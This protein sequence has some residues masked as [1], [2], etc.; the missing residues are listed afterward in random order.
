MAN[1]L[2]K[3][4]RSK[5][6]DW[7]EERF[8]ESRQV[9]LNLKRI[10][11]FPTASALALL[12]TIILLFVMGVNFQNSLA[13]GLS[14]WLL[15]LIVISIFFTYRN[16][17]GI[18][19]KAVNANPCFAGEKAVFE[20]ALSCPKEQHK[21]AVYIGWKDQDVALVDLNEQHSAS[22][23]LS[24]TTEKR[25]R[26]KP[27]RLNI[28]TRYPVGL[29]LGWSYAQLNME[30]IVYPVPLLQES[31]QNGQSMDD[32]AEQ[33]LEIQRG[34]TDFSGIRDYQAGDSPKHIHWGSYAKTGKVFSKTFVDYASH[35]LWLDWEALEMQ[36]VETKLS[37][38]CALILQYH[39]EQQFY[40]LKI[41]GRTIEPANGE[42]HKNTCLM[43]LALFG[44]GGQ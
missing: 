41:P 15:A 26:F 43:A 33:G 32:E 30:S 31:K 29:V 34:T 22:V 23:K 17:S 21:S 27:E 13:Y 2:T 1:I 37:H 18:T 28:F 38:L 24:H 6:N 39:E 42:A 9:T 25:G 5:T 3:S 11:V 10:F 36:G 7:I 14:F 4:W 16:L 20:L 40:G 44:E 8:P 19:V 12:V 35:D